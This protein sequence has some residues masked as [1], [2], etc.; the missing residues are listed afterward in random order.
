MA[1]GWN[2]ITEKADQSSFEGPFPSDWEAMNAKIAAQ[3]ALNGNSSRGGLWWGLGLGLLLLISAGAGFWY[4]N[5]NSDVQQEEA[6][7]EQMISPV[8]VEATKESV[9]ESLQSHEKSYVIEEKHSGTTD[10]LDEI[11]PNQ[12]VQLE[13]DVQD[14]ILSASKEE[15]G[16]KAE[17]TADAESNTFAESNARNESELVAASESAIESN[18]LVT[19]ELAEGEVEESNSIAEVKAEDDEVVSENEEIL[20]AEAVDNGTEAMAADE[21]ELL[22]TGVV[23]DEDSQ[24]EPLILDFDDSSSDDVV[25]SLMEDEDEGDPVP[26]NLRSMGFQ[27][28]S[29]SMGAKYLTDYS[30]DFYGV[31]A[32]VDVD[33]QKGG[34]LINTGVS[35]YQL[36][37]SQ[38]V[39]DNW[40][41]EEYDTS[42]VTTYDTINTEVKYPVWVIEGPYQGRY[43][44]IRYTTRQ[45]DSLV[46]EDVDTTVF[47]KSETYQQRVKLSYIEMPILLGHRFRFNRFAVDLYGG[48]A[49]SQTLSSNV[50]GTDLDQ[51]F[52]LTAVLQ[53]G[54]RYYFTPSWS[55]H[56]RSGLRYGLMADEFRKKKLHSNFHVGLTYHW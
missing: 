42:R 50:E 27:L 29:I 14:D 15:Q 23:V 49:L 53:P 5:M 54:V 10:A 34:L 3:P 22:E 36:N 19:H 56:A 8:E 41:E 46:E 2:K 32:G 26:V 44:T 17:I 18:T 25:A 40:T 55:L 11:E 13:E 37:T 35:Y 4:F 28:N 24:E 33:I 31:G 47:T 30:G 45:I 39:T 12:V 20:L 51:K 21:P 52:G 6:R 38:W 9:D 43:D 16:Y 48:V 1:G 7:G